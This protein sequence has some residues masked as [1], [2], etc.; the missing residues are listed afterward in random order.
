MSRGT[1]HAVHSRAGRLVALERLLPPVRALTPPILPDYYPR[2]LRRGRTAA[3]LT[4]L[5]AALC[6]VFCLLATGTLEAQH[7]KKRDY[8]HEVEGLEEQ[9]RVAQLAGDVAAMDRLLAEDYVGISVN[10]EVN[11]KTQQLDRLRTRS[12]ILSKIAFSDMKVKLVGPVAIVTSLADIE[13]SS[14]GVVI[15]GQYRYT[16]VYQRLASGAWKIT[17]FE[18]TRRIPRKRDRA[19]QSGSD[20]PAFNAVL[21]A[22]TKP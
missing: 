16:R 5:C 17:N 8:K 12:L 18:L 21:P 19:L 10:G 2:M 13:G 9:W 14:N 22:N 1:A 11:T 4:L 7:H 15:N 20:D 6:L 3:L